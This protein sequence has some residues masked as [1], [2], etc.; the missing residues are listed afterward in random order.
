M[1]VV[2]VP[3]EPPASY[4]KSI[5]L[6]GPSPRDVAHLNWR[7]EALKLL[8]EL[9]YDGV[10]FVPL[11]ENGDWRHGYDAQVAWERK[12]LDVADQIVFWVPRD[13]RALPA[14]TT[15]V[16]FGAYYDS[17]RAVLG[18]PEGAPHMNYL[19]TLAVEQGA[20]VVGDLAAALRAA[21]TKIGDGARREGGERDVPLFI[22]LLPHFQSWLRAQK[23]AGNRLDGARLLWAFRTGP[24]ESFGFS[25]ALHVNV[26]V[27]SE[28][29]NK[30]DEFV[31]ARPDVM[32]V[33]AYCEGRHPRA[34]VLE[35][36][37]DT[38]IVIVREFRSPASVGDCMIREVP[39]G[40]SWKPWDDPFTT[41]AHELSE[42]TGLTV[43]VSRLKFLSRRQVAGTLSAHRAYVFACVLTRAEMD[44]LKADAAS[45]R[46][47][48]VEADTERTYVEVRTVRELLA[49]PLT[50]WA[51]LGMVFAALAQDRA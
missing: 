1:I 23:E 33:V 29:R 42:E 41:A 25:F 43:D 4:S 37:L 26:R 12:Y 2:R 35:T 14:L 46:H 50:D 3:N 18:Y 6:A 34:T 20:P 48:G 7:P 17:G 13:M 38:E 24:T 22:W 15:N 16:E 51:N 47:H 30:V 31:L 5:F 28:G 36:L 21:I 45:G 40:S 10:V 8:E 11:P 32:A 44:A 9:G 49:E 39:G 19:K 27:A